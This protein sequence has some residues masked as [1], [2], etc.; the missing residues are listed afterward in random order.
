MPARRSALR[1]FRAE[2]EFGLLVGGLLLA[3][4]GWWLWRGKFDALRPLFFALGAPLVVAGALLPRAL[5]LPRRAWM[6][7][8]EL[9]ARVVTTLILAFV[10]FAVVTP[11]GVVKRLAGWDPLERRAPPGSS[12]WRHYPARQRDPRH[13]EK[14]Y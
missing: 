11:I 14:M 7:L 5:V 6:A 12:F 2:R 8:A 9:L 1:S 3:L 13:F 10:F 4:G